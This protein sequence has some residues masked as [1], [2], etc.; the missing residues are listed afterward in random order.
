VV[1][2]IAHI[3]LVLVGAKAQGFPINV[4]S[5]LIPLDFKLFWTNQG[6]L[7]HLCFHQVSQIAE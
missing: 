4:K 7:I 1:T 2:A 6:I 3:V 5:S